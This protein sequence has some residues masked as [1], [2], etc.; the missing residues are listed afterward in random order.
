MN[1][2]RSFIESKDHHCDKKYKA[3]SQNFM[4]NKVAYEGYD[5]DEEYDAFK[6]SV[7][8]CIWQGYRMCYYIPVS[9]TIPINSSPIESCETCGG[10]PCHRILF[11]RY[12]LQRMV[13]TKKCYDEWEEFAKEFGKDYFYANEL[14]SYNKNPSGYDPQYIDTDKNDSEDVDEPHEF[15]AVPECV[16]DVF[17]AFR[18]FLITRRSTDN[19]GEELKV[20]LKTYDKNSLMK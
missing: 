10:K 13:N 3:T 18:N 2:K 16:C 7:D 19:W 14:T 4:N 1:N 6:E 5:P 12:L 11:G 9:E 15:A 20:F 17:Y 8:F